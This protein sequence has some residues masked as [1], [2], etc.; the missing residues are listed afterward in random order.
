[1]AS[2]ARKFPSPSRAGGGNVPYK[3]SPGGYGNP[4]PPGT[5]ANDNFLRKF[6]PV[7]RRLNFLFWYE[8]ILDAYQWGRSLNP[9]V[10]GFILC[11]VHTGPWQGDCAIYPASGD[12]RWQQTAVSNCGNTSASGTCPQ[13]TQTV[14]DPAGIPLIEQQTA[15][16]RGFRILKPSGTERVRLTQWYRRINPIPDSTPPVVRPNPQPVGDPANPDPFTPSPTPGAIPSHTPWALPPLV[17]MPLP[18][19]LPWRDI[20][21]RPQSDPLKEPAPGEVRPDEGNEASNGLNPR[22]V[23]VPY[24]A[25][26]LWPAPN[27]RVARRHRLRPPGRGVKERKFIGNV[28]PGSTLGKI[29][30]GVTEANDLVNCI[31]KALPKSKQAK[32]PTIQNK[33][34]AI[35][36]NFLDVDVPAAILNCV[37]NE[38]EDR[39]YAKVGRV[40]AQVNRRLGLTGGTLGRTSGNIGRA[41]K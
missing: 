29:F 2:P 26:Q 10:D 4:Y 41:L 9:R 28:A 3:F 17:P 30:S 38:I 23:A 11:R 12:V 14:P 34:A 15:I 39:F 22:P 25:L 35:Y 32:S 21:T 27:G 19:P 18:I 7:L 40:Q 20:P 8:D 33:A 6:A 13:L 31:H 37:A 16:A 36:R 24:P 1:M 5:A